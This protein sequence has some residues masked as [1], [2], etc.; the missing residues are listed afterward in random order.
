MRQSINVPGTKNSHEVIQRCH[1][2]LLSRDIFLT[3][4][5]Q[6]TEKVLDYLKS[7]GHGSYLFGQVATWVHN[8]NPDLDH[9]SNWI[10]KVHDH[11]GRLPRYGCI[12]Y[13][14]VDDPFSDAAWNEGV[15]K[16]WDRG[17]IVGVLQLL[18]EPWRRGME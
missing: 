11:T 8:E 14:F 6:S 9:P 18:C 7:R 17:M 2:R 16:L 5:A 12:T 13:D 1:L 4:H 3:A 15:K 10:K